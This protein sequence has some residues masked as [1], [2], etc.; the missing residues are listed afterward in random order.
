M[1]RNS[2]LRLRKP[3][4]QESRLPYIKA[5]CF[6]LN[7]S[8]NQIL[9]LIDQHRSICTTTECLKDPRT[10]K[11]EMKYFWNKYHQSDETCFNY[12]LG[13]HEQ[14]VWSY[15]VIINNFRIRSSIPYS[16]TVAAG[17]G[18]MDKKKWLN[19]NKTLI[20]NTENRYKDINA[21]FGPL[22][23]TINSQK[24]N[25]LS[26]NN[27]PEVAQSL[28]FDKSA[29]GG[30]GFPCP[31]FALNSIIKLDGGAYARTMV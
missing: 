25:S 10:I 3:T 22:L 7:L 15:L 27:Y 14:S 23:K 13:R 5:N 9:D 31:D 8:S 1:F 18:S 24:I 29:Y 20:S 19:K 2:N 30:L 17:T 12:K 21:T 4:S 16:Y 28:Y 11:G 6:G 26:S